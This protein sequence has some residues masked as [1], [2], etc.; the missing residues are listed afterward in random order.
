MENPALAVV[1]DYTCFEVKDSG[2]GMDEE[3]QKRIFDPYFT[4]KP[5]GAGTRL[6]LTVVHGI[7]QEYKGA[8]RVKSGVGIVT[9]FRILLPCRD[10]EV[11]KD[12][13]WVA[14]EL[15]KGKGHILVAEDEES[16]ANLIGRTLEKM[17]YTV[18]IQT[19]SFKALDIF[20][21]APYA[22]DLVTT[23][24]TMPQ[25]TGVALIREICSIRPDLP[26]I[27]FT[28]FSDEATPERERQLGVFRHFY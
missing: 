9:T 24:Q 6:G 20:R 21:S 12:A 23:D 27:L 25:M 13:P 28:G 10:W 1:W 14:G 18:I 11:T 15:Q 17:G 2:H 16:I 26:T 7:V 22:H 5:V 19:T 4:T 8:V 3:T